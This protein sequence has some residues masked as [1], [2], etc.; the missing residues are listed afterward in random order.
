MGALPNIHRKYAELLVDYSLAVKPGER[1]IVRST[2][3]AEPLLR[4]VYRRI[5]EAGGE[6]ELKVQYDWQQSLFYEHA[7]DEVLARSPDIYRH[8]VEHTDATLYI[9]ASQNT[10]ET[11]G[12]DPERQKARAKLMMPI[13]E[14]IM[15]MDAGGE[16]NVRWCVTLFPTAASAQDAE[17]AI[18]DYERFV[19]SAMFL[20]REDPVQ[21]W[22]GLAASQQSLADLL[23]AS[24]EVRI[25]GK[26]TDLTLGIGGRH[27]VNS[28]G[29]HNMPSGEVFTAP[30][31]DAVNGVVT[32]SEFPQVYQGKEVLGARLEFRDGKV[33]AASAAKNEE[34]LIKMLDSDDGSRTLGELGIGTNAGIQ[35]HVR[36]IL[37]DEKI[38]G[39]VHLALGR[40]YDENG[41][42][43]KSAIHWDLI[44]DLRGLGHL[45]I[46]GA[47]YAWD[48]ERWVPDPF[49]ESGCGR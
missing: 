23:N 20:D 32:F 41:G 22:N 2:P 25:V 7:S 49:T 1:V 35:R 9:Y 36:H 8:E 13:Q 17:M 37:F 48:G 30:L 38:G 34:F 24:K 5:L 18:W 16:P 4:E 46:D 28:D 14:Y 19:Y 12:S 47:R 45:E 10:R 11:S 29:R 44:K 3:E 43:N 31:E 33:V 40:A 26:D 15:G 39:S 21:A 42:T 6:P 27:A